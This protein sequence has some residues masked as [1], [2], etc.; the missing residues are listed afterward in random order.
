MQE[1]NEIS[2]EM[3]FCL[4][5]ILRDQYIHIYRG[6]LRY[7]RVLPT[8][9]M[10]RSGYK[11]EKRFK[12]LFVILHRHLR[13]RTARGQAIKTLSDVTGETIFASGSIATDI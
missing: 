4:V 7:S 5:K 3:L 8:S 10:F 12:L 1:L 11:M 9:P 2:F 6:F 13:M